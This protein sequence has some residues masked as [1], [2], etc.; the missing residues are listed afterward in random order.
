MIPVYKNKETGY[1]KLKPHLLSKTEGGGG[2]R[3]QSKKPNFAL[4]YRKLRDLGANVGDPKDFFRDYNRVLAKR[5]VLFLLDDLNSA[6]FINSKTA[7]VVKGEATGV[8]RFRFHLG[9]DDY[10]VI[11]FKRGVGGR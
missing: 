2:L 11:D 5:E 4:L 3:W 10:F 7:E 8:L 9:E 1:K 6:F